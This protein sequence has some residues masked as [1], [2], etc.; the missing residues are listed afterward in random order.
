MTAYNAV[1][2]DNLLYMT[3]K[4]FQEHLDVLEKYQERFSYIMIDEYQDTN[5]VQYL[6]ADL[7]SKKSGNLCVVGD[8]DQAI[9]GWR[10]AEIKHILEFE[11]NHLIKL[12]Q[13]YRS[14]HPILQ[15]A[16]S[17]IKNNSKETQ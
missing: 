16:N 15:A 7:L 9:Y 6:V 14:T 11:N 10:G 4:L 2:F 17:V 1:D 8:D 13:N 12:E 5:G 3:L